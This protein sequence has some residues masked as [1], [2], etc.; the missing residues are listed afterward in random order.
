[1]KKEL[2][3]RDFK[4][5]Q[6]ALQK[7]ISE[8]IK[9]NEWESEDEEIYKNIEN[10]I[11]AYKIHKE[12][13]EK[14][15]L[16]KKEKQKQIEKLQRD[17]KKSIIYKLCCKDPNITEIYVGSTTNFNR[18]KQGHKHACN[19]ENA[20]RYNSKVYKVIRD[21]G[22]WDNWDMIQIE[23]YE[24]ENKRQ[25]E[26]K[27]RYYIETLKSSLNGKIPT[28]TAKEYYQQNK[29]KKKQKRKERYQKKKLEQAN[30]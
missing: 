13:K 24:C 11:G 14:K 29:D 8:R 5:I 6:N 19:Y 3:I 4:I 26:S 21:N 18:R 12:E 27:E 1:M 15:K 22:N 10:I 17:Y 20:K 2:T 23:E 25:L 28:R 30:N 7:T 9:D 16:L